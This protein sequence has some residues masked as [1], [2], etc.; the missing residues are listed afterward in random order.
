MVRFRPARDPAGVPLR[1]T[2]DR[3][4]TRCG[5]RWRLVIRASGLI[6]HFSERPWPHSPEPWR[7]TISGNFLQASSAAELEDVVV[8]D[9]LGDGAVKRL[10]PL[11]RPR[12]GRGGRGHVG[13]GDGEVVRVAATTTNVVKIGAVGAC[14]VGCPPPLRAASGGSIF[15]GNSWF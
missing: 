15:G 10:A 8:A 13:G 12:G 11:R 14:S 1:M 4:R 9:G 5:R 6:R 7:K 2:I 3:G